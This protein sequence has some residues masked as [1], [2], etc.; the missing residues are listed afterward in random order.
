MIWPSR[1]ESTSC[2]SACKNALRDGDCSVCGQELQG[3]GIVECLTALLAQWQQ[4][5]R[6]AAEQNAQ[7]GPLRRGIGV[8]SC[9]YGCGNIALPN[10]SIVR[11]G[12]TAD[13]RLVLHQG[14]TDIGQGANTVIAQICADALGLPVAKVDLVGPDT[15]ITPDCG[16]TSASR[17]TVITGKAALRAG[18]ALRTQIHAH[19]NMRDTA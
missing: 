15:A 14:A 8:A 19:S 2:S 1:P 7:P 18:A 16:K 5:K 3:V 6:R 9:W 17:Q 11:L 10:P 13:G 4:A 12:L